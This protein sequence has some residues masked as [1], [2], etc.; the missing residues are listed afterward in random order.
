MG[1]TAGSVTGALASIASAAGPV[2]LAAA[3]VGA[4]YLAFNEL[5]KAITGTISKL[6][7]FAS[8]LV[9]PDANP[10]QFVALVGQGF[11]ELGDKL[12]I[13]NPLMGVFAHSLGAVTESLA[14]LMSAVDG[15]VSRYAEV[16]PGLALAEAQ[17][18]LT[19]T[20]ADFRRGQQ[21][22]PELVRYVQER[23]ELQQKYED[24]KA[25]M[26]ERLTPLI[27]AGMEHLAVLIPLVESLVDLVLSIAEKHPLLAGKV[28]EIKDEIKRI[29]EE[30]EDPT[31]DMWPTGSIMGAASGEAFGRRFFP[32]GG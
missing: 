21:V 27:V 19:Q 26:L 9:S 8:T 2:G 7:Q 29:R 17:A 14:Q 15:M 1:G 18:D 16:S 28:S 6:G 4:L 12:F 25:R 32:E 5:D 13:L 11:T 23:T 3:A 31:G 22:A 30:L 10:Q 20:L 24:A